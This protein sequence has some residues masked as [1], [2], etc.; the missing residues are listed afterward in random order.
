MLQ[1]NN[2][3]LRDRTHYKLNTF[4]YLSILYVTVMVSVQKSDI[5]SR[6]RMDIATVLECL[7]RLCDRPLTRP[8]PSVPLCRSLTTGS[9]GSTSPTMTS[10]G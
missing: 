2:T 4:S 3:T 8:S 9:E 5:L 6:Y 1:A 7:S 10:P